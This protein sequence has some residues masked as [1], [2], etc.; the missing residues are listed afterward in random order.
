M[1][2]LSLRSNGGGIGSN[3]SLRSSH[4][5]LVFRSSHRFYRVSISS[6][7][8]SR[9]FTPLSVDPNEAWV[10]IVEKAYAK[11]H[12]CYE[13]LMD[14]QIEYA[15]EDATGLASMK[16]RLSEPKFADQVA[17]GEM[18]QKLKAYG[19]DKQLLAF[20]RSRSSDPRVHEGKILGGH[21]YPVVDVCEL[22]A[23]AT[24][25]LEALDVQLVRLVDRFGIGAGWQGG[26]SEV[27]MCEE[28]SE[29]QPNFVS[30]SNFTTTSL[31]LHDS[32][33]SLVAVLGHVGGLPRHQEDRGEEARNPQLLLDELARRL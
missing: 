30:V 20:S 26:W 14:G 12:G 25:D 4:S 15:L 23:D 10:A 31:S 27:R 2:V 8:L 1:E 16:F 33:A 7:S 32:L 3:S 21:A 17:S 9:R 13:S 18:W 29:D 5:A 19:D 22:H 28:R 11:L 6:L 24:P